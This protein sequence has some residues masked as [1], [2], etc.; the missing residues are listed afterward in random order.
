MRWILGVGLVAVLCACTSGAP[1]PEPS[2]ALPAGLADGQRWIL[3]DALG[4]REG[5][6]P[7]A[8][9][10]SLTFE[11]G[12][13]SGRAPVNT[14]FAEYELRGPSALAIGPIARTEMAGEP[15]RMAAE[16]AYFDLLQDVDGYTGDGEQLTLLRGGEPVLGFGPD[17][18]AVA[19]GAGLV[20]LPV[21]EARELA[22]SEGFAFRV[23]SVDGEGRPATTDYR[24]DRINAT[25][26]DGRLTGVTVG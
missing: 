8:Y 2:A 6:D 23:V 25:V 10:V 3:V 17:G 5:R 18:S 22:R 11:R 7:A 26:V 21:A 4:P 24:P 15:D 12:Q 14:Y 9:G 13:L 20:G 16:D 19:I 1:I